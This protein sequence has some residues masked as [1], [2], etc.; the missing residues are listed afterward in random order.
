MHPCLQTQLDED[1]RKR[2]IVVNALYPATHHNKIADPD[3]LELY[4][5][6]EGAR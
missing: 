6:E 2:G 5:D 3:G 1:S 4:D